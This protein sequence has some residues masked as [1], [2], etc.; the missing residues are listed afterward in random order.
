MRSITVRQRPR[1]SEVISA[2]HR[3]KAAITKAVFKTKRN[4]LATDLTNMVNTH[5]DQAWEALSTNKFQHW[6]NQRLYDPSDPPN[7][8]DLKFSF[9]DPRTYGVREY[10]E[11]VIRGNEKLIK[12]KKY[13]DEQGLKYD[14]K[15]DYYSTRGSSTEHNTIYKL[16][17]DLTPAEKR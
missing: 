6:V 4:K 3:E 12:L 9:E 2:A 1:L 5:V 11:S 8:I 13:L 16:V 17:L 7:L 15:N 14:E 10:L